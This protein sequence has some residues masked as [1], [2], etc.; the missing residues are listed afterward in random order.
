MKN[1]KYNFSYRSS[2]TDSIEAE[3]GTVEKDASG[4]NGLFSPERFR[5]EKIIRKLLTKDFATVLDIGAGKKEQ[6]DISP[7]EP[8]S[9]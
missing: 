4:F 1:Q 5:G 7:K 3:L 6:V 2:S 8:S 9:F